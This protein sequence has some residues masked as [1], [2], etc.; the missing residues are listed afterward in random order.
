MAE[1]GFLDRLLET[2]SR[3]ERTMV[4]GQMDTGKSTLVKNVADRMGALVL[5]TD[6]GQNDIGPPATVTIGE[7]AGGRYRRIDGYFCGSVSPSRHFLQ[8][9]AGLSRLLARA[10]KRPVLI[11]TT[12]L[13]TG[14]IGR[15]LKT[16]KINAARP[17]LIIG[18]EF[19][20]ELKYL[21]AFS[22]AGIEVLRFKPHPEVR[23]RS[24]AVRDRTREAMFQAHFSGASAS[25]HRLEEIAIERSLL[26]NGI[27]ADAA[28]LSQFAGARVVH[29]EVA[30][31][32]GLIIFGDG[33][34]DLQKMAP[35][36]EVKVLYSY[37]I[38][39]FPGA[40]VGLYGERGLFLGLGLIESIDFTEGLVHVFSTVREFSLMQFGSMRLNPSD[41]TSAGPLQPQVYRHKH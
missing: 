35:E 7:R 28:T 14:D 9:I 10:G 15:A 19:E 37:H 20:D 22:R 34:V 5:D 32:E 8:M 16:E 23:D 11:N 3:H 25:A 38:M 36:L 29:A 27:P 24:R 41:F 1:N 21:D 17:D 13:A 18:L 2:V 31:N 12:G 39:D 30:G 40:L 33:R 6:I 4:I 26:G